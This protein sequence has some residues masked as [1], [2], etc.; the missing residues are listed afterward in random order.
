MKTEPTRSSVA[1]VAF[2]AMALG[3][4]P[5]SAQIN[6]S[7]AKSVSLKRPADADR[8]TA[9]GAG[10]T[11]TL[12]LEIEVLVA[13]ERVRLARSQVHAIRAERPP[14]RLA[15]ILAN[16]ELIERL[17]HC[18]WLRRQLG[19]ETP[20]LERMERLRLHLRVA[21][22]RLLAD[23]A[24]E[25]LMVERNAVPSLP[26]RLCKRTL[27]LSAALIELGTRQLELTHRLDKDP[28]AAEKL[29]ARRQQLQALQTRAKNIRDRFEDSVA[30][31]ELEEIADLAQGADQLLSKLQ[32]FVDQAD[33]LSGT[34]SQRIRPEEELQKTMVQT[35]EMLKKAEELLPIRPAGIKGLLVERLALLR[36][37]ERSRRQLNEIN[38]NSPTQDVIPVLNDLLEAELE[39]CE[40]QAERIACREK[41]AKRLND[42]EKMVQAE[43]EAHTLPMHEYIQTRI[44][45]LDAEIG[46]RRERAENQSPAE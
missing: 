39:L 3:S 32:Q 16:E 45:R 29:D 11:G 40:T 35:D 42:L 26:L 31:R 25:P 22:A 5:T 13:A 20:E 24:R 1:A 41:L 2:L 30:R 33:R 8:P 15:I 21:K 7:S 12:S 36:D 17:R 14:R 10:M 23:Q 28:D 46:L 27:D 44:R 4:M 38:R 18:L 43:V 9:T 6:R 34:P 37:L 19:F